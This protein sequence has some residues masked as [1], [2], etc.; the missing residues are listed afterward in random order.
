MPGAKVVRIPGA[1]AAAASDDG[2][3]VFSGVAGT[4]TITGTSNGPALAAAQTFILVPA[5]TNSGAVTLN[6][7]AVKKADGTA[8]A[9]GDLVANKT[10]FLEYDGTVFRLLTGGLLSANEITTDLGTSTG[11][12][13]ALAVAP[14]GGATTFETNRLYWVKANLTNTGATTL[15]SNGGSAVA[16]RKNPNNAA[17][18][19]GEIAANGLLLLRYDGTY[20]Q[21]VAGRTLLPGDMPAGFV[22][23]YGTTGGA[24]NAYTASAPAGVEPMSALVDGTT[25]LVKIH[26]NNNSSPTFAPDGLAAKNLV[27]PTS[28]GNLATAQL[29]ANRHYLFTYNSTTDK[30]EVKSLYT[31]DAYDIPT[32]LS[33]TTFN[34]TVTLKNDI[35]RVNS[36]GSTSISGNSVVG[37]DNP[38]FTIYGSTHVNSAG[39]I[40]LKSYGVTRASSGTWTPIFSLAKGAYHGDFYLSDSLGDG[41]ARYPVNG[42]TLGTVVD[43]A[44]GITWVDAGSVGASNVGLRINSGNVEINVGTSVTA[45]TRFGIRFE[46]IVI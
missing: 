36:V 10:H 24:T 37:T 45:S 39:A 22:H 7:I 5:N 12:A 1:A 32:T 16:I 3:F 33:P 23:N 14:A 8:L 27:R 4:N 30:W 44:S 26:A 31:L 9:A 42:T 11:T 21:L 20:L 29:I 17:L 38:E 13:N 35:I 34:G 40:E 46:G 18:V 43:A 15:A 28:G 2:P 6:G 19:G 25:V 41:H